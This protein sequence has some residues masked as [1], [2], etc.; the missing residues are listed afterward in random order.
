MRMIVWRSIERRLK[1]HECSLELGLT[2]PTL[3]HL[4]LMLAQLDPF[5]AEPTLSCAAILR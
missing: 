5:R 3:Q 1:E 4:N 2:V